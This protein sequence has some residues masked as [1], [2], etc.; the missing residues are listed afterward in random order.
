[1]TQEQLMELI[2][3]LSERKERVEADINAL[4]EE[5][6][7]IGTYENI[8]DM[9]DLA[10]L[11]QLNDSDKALLQKLLDEKKAIQK[12]LLKIKEGTYGKCSDG[13]EI[14]FEKLKADPLYEC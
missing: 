3:I 2:G 14:P 7:E 4:L 10:Q 12:A 11:E 5:L 1:M 8:D 9:E 13:T 6:E